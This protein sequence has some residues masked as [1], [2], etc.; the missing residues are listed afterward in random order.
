MVNFQRLLLRLRSLHVTNDA[1]D[2]HEARVWRKRKGGKKAG[3]EQRVVISRYWT[4]TSGERR[5]EIGYRREWH[6]SGLIN[7]RFTASPSRLI[8]K[9]T[10]PNTRETVLFEQLA[11]VQESWQMES[12][13][14]RGKRVTNWSHMTKFLESEPG[15]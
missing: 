15:N 6:T 13:S 2:E 7:R 9:R 5:G 12:N 3:A 8:Y 10:V 11:G 1:R 14:G 4:K